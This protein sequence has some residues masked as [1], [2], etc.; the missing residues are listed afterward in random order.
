MDFR[1]QA[2][3]P[4]KAAAREAKS[5]TGTV[6][7]LVSLDAAAIFAAKI[8]PVPDFA[9]YFGTLRAPW[10]QTADFG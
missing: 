10:M 3:G 6:F 1:M 2:H 5:G 4:G 8:V 7:R 9:V